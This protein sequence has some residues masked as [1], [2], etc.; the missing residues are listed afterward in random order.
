MAFLTAKRILHI[1]FYNSIVL[2]K[3]GTAHW[4]CALGVGV[5]AVGLNLKTNRFHPAGIHSQQI[6]TSPLG[7]IYIHDL[8]GAHVRGLRQ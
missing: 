2:S 5:L 7:P 4:I 8:S 1:V 6:R 3:C